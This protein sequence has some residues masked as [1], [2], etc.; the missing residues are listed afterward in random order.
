MNKIRY[1]I[2][3]SIIIS[4]FSG[5]D[6]DEKYNTSH[7]E[8]GGIILTMDWSN[9]TAANPSTYQA[10]V[11]S[12]SGTSRIFENLSGTENNLVVEPGDAILL[13]YNHAENITI[14]GTKAI[15]NNIGTGIATNPGLFFSYFGEISTLRDRD[16]THTALMRQ[17]TGELKISFAIK[18]ANMINRINRISATLEGV[19]SELEMKT[20][21]LSGSSLITTTFTQNSYYAAT[22]VRLFGFDPST[23]QHL[24]LD[25]EFKNGSQS[26]ITSDLI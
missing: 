24:I 21:N 4:T 25:I 7:P 1:F 22:M 20:N 8:E 16:M 5:C 26:T 14:S 12:S 3:I 10:R 19:A 15:I 11:T 6:E 2:L 23:R 18:P 13:I 9:I 17:Q